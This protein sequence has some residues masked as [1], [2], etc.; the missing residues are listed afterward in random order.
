MLSN[1]AQ[2]GSLCSSTHQI[3]G[4]GSCSLLRPSSVQGCL[5]LPH[6]R[7]SLAQ[8]A[9]FSLVPLFCLRQSQ[10]RGM[11]QTHQFLLNSFALYSPP[12]LMKCRKNQHSCTG[13]VVAETEG[14]HCA[15]MVI[16]CPGNTSNRSLSMLS[17][18]FTLDCSSCFTRDW[19]AGCDTSDLKL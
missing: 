13:L 7:G 6:P 10:L 18:P 1:D 8:L 14:H 19:Q 12:A 17:R 4:A 5:I 11:T 16:Q 2:K 9:D 3:R 15:S